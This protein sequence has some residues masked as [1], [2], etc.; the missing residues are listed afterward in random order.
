M[1][2][3][4]IELDTVVSGKPQVP[5]WSTEEI[6]LAVTVHP[7]FPGKPRLARG[8]LEECNQR[9]GHS[10]LS[11]EVLDRLAEIQKKT[12]ASASHWD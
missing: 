8:L 7:E 4:T 6:L 12:P 11:E 9:S 1:E 3:T 10:P 5:N 2:S